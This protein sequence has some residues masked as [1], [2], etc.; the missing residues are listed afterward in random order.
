[1]KISPISI[2]LVLT[3]ALTSSLV[4]QKA[5][6]DPKVEAP[7]KVQPWSG[8]FVHDTERPLPTKVA[9][10]S[11]TTTPAPADADIIFDGKDSSAFTKEWTVKDGILIATRTGTNPTKKSYGSCQLHLEWR[12]P[13]DRAVDGQK[14]G[15]SGVFLM[16]KYEIQIMES[17]TNTTY[18]DGQAAA[19][20]G[21]YPPLVNASLPQGEWQSYDITFI[22]PVYKDG[23]VLKPAT[24][25]LLHNGVMVHNAQPYQ[26]P[27][28]PKRIA[29]YPA[30]HPE[31]APLK[32]QWHSDP[33]EYRN[34]WI[35]ETGDYGTKPEVK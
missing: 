32:L 3:L 1:M 28:G 29:K 25:T 17:H 33:I 11:C 14:G 21:Q 8:Y 2:P 4:A 9:V 7:L 23:K 19:M 10:T 13:A 35:R 5:E 12:V 31:K 22:A 24:I 20:Y 34:I 26:G 6:A 16:G 30:K 18:A 27:T 15:N